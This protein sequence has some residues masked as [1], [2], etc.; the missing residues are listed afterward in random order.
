M[1]GSYES[2]HFSHFETKLHLL[3]VAST[4][5]TMHAKERNALGL[6]FGHRKSS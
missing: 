5:V 1:R 3:N 6:L 4:I 2:S